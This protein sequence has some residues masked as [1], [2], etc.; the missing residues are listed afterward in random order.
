[1]EADVK[2][3]YIDVDNN[4]IAASTVER[5]LA[6]AQVVNPAI[7]AVVPDAPDAVVAKGVDAAILYYHRLDHG[8][9]D[10]MEDYIEIVFLDDYKAERCATI[11]E[12]TSELT[13]LGFTH[14]NGEDVKLSIN[15]THLIIYLGLD[16]MNAMGLIT[17]PVPYATL[18]GEP[19]LIT[20]SADLNSIIA[21]GGAALMT[22]RVGGVLLRNAINS[23]MTK[24]EIDAIHDDR[25]PQ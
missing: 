10:V 11:D 22:I 3:V 9:G 6:E 5:T 21:Q 17:W 20:D 18:D 2:T 24:A 16:K 12:R 4:V 25:Q 7:V 23:A 19:Y 8:D 14:T 13:A 15:N 1:M